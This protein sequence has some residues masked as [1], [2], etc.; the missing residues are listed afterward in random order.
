[1]T[2]FLIINRRAGMVRLLFS[3]KGIIMTA[4]F[5]LNRG[6]LLCTLALAFPALGVAEP[7]LVVTAQ[8]Q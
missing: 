5:P 1:M 4:L 7:S 2:L 3:A 8:P 6:R